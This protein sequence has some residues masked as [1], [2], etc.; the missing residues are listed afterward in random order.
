[1]KHVQELQHMKENNESLRCI[2]LFVIQRND[3]ISFQ[4]SNLDIQYKNAIETAYLKG[5]EII[6][7]QVH[8][9]ENGQCFYDRVLPFIHK[10]HT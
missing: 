10:N 8:W 3:C 2:L 5:V 4:A 7:I 6:P 1:M 9:N